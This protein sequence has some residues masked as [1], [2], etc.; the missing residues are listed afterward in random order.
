[1]RDM[2]TVSRS[3]SSTCHPF[4]GPCPS[5]RPAQPWASPRDSS[6]GPAPLSAWF[7]AASLFLQ[8][9]RR[10]V[11]HSCPG[12]LLWPLSCLGDGGAA[13]CP[14]SYGQSEGTGL[15]VPPA[16]SLSN[17][18]P[19]WDKMGEPKPPP[20][21]AHSL[22]VPS[23]MASP[24]HFPRAKVECISMALSAR[25][26]LSRCRSTGGSVSGP[27]SQARPWG[28]PGV[29]GP[30]GILASAFLPHLRGI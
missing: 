16:L 25:I 4:P 19:Q 27:T 1:M 17:S 2:P 7:A 13:H 6:R 30:S 14:L 11:T 12:P 28:A 26:A 29:L 21:G 22:T 18:G 23:L 20:K 5:P 10:L 9:L 3:L 8:P 24:C 15:F